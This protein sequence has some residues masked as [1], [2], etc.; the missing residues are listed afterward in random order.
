MA[1]RWEHRVRAALLG[2]SQDSLSDRV[3]AARVVARSWLARWGRRIAVAALA[4]AALTAMAAGA[5]L[6]LLVHALA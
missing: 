2:A 1:V 4:M 5:T 3:Q 6:A